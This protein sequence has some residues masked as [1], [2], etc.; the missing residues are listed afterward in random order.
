VPIISEL[1]AGL[2]LKIVAVTPVFGF[3]GNADMKYALLK[4]G[5]VI[6]DNDEDTDRYLEIKLPGDIPG[7]MPSLFSA[8][9]GLGV[10]VYRINTLGDTD[11]LSYSVIF[12]DGGGGFV[13][14]L[15]YLS[16]FIGEY[17]PIGIYKNLE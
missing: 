10:S 17:V 9:E 15:T 3:E 6:P 11:S 16:V 4:R 8:A 7:G 13:S 1:A 12:K 5:F 2:G 14:L